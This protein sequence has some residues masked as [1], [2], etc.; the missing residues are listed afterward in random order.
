MSED[1]FHLMGRG[2]GLIVTVGIWEVEFKKK[3]FV[4]C[5]ANLDDV[6]TKASIGRSNNPFIVTWNPAVLLM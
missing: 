1:N 4:R 2:G 5:I 3:H 6:Y